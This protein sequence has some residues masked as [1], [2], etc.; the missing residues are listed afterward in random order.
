MNNRTLLLF[1]FGLLLF[2]GPAIAQKNNVNVNP[3]TGTANVV[4]PLYEFKRGQV[5][6]PINISYAASGIKPKDVEGTAGMGWQFNAGGQ[7]TRQVRGLPDDC[8]KDNTNLDRKGWMNNTN[9]TK[10]NSFSIANDNNPATC[11][12]GTNDVNYINTNFADLS[13]TEPDI[14]YVNAPGL[15]CQL[16]YDQVNSHFRLMDHQDVTIAYAANLPTAAS[17]P[18]AITSFT[19]TNDKGVR[20]IF[21]SPD[22]VVQTTKDGTPT[23]YKNKYDQYKNG[24]S[25]FNNW[26]LT[27]IL[28][29]NGSGVTFQYNFAAHFRDSTDPVSLYTP[30]ASTPTLQYNVSQRVTPQLLSVIRNVYNGQIADVLNFTWWWSSTASYFNT[31][32]GKY[33]EYGTGANLIKKIDGAGMQ[34]EFYY[35]APDDGDPV[36]GSQY[37]RYFLRSFS[38]YRCGSPINYSFRYAGENYTPGTTSYQSTL[39]DSSTKKIDYW[40]YYSTSNTSTT[41]IMPKVWI[42]ASTVAIP[43]YAI[44]QTGTTGG[45]YPYYTTN[46]NIRSADPTN[47]ISGSLTKIYYPE[48]GSTTLTYESNDYLDVPSG[49]VFPGNGIRTKQTVDDDGSGSGNLITTNYSYLDPATGISSGKPLSLPAFAF[50]IPYN[51][52][53]TGNAL[54][55]SCTVVSDNDLSYE[56]HTIMYAY[57]K[58]SKSGAGSTLYQYYIP[59]SYWNTSSTPSCSGCTVADWTPTVN[60]MQRITCST[61]TGP[62][63]KNTYGYPFTP[64]TNYDFER[65]LIK[66]TTYFNESGT[67]VGESNY[68]YQRS[69]QPSVITAL[70]IEDVPFSNG[71][72][73]VKTFAKYTVNYKVSELLVGESALVYDPSTLTLV[74][75]TTT[76]YSFESSNHR[77]MT[78]KAVTNSDNS[79]ITTQIKYV[80]DFTGL[81]TSSNRN[82]NALYNMQLL[83]QNI[84]VETYEQV[85]RAGSTKTTSASLVLFADFPAATGGAYNYRPFAQYSLTSADGLVAFSPSSVSLPSTYNKDP[86]YFLTANYSEYDKLGDLQSSDDGHHNV[87]ATVLDNYHNLPIISIHNAAAS[88]IGFAD[89][90]SNMLTPWVFAKTGTSSYTPPAGSHTGLATGLGTGQVISFQLKKN[91]LAT[92]YVLSAWINTTAAGNIAFSFSAASGTS[93][94]PPQILP[95]TG[96][97]WKYQEWKVSLGTI[98]GAFTINISTTVNTGV[99]DVIFYPENAEVS[100]YSYDPVT[101]FKASATNTNGISTYFTDDIW[102]RP[103]LT[104]DQDHN[105]VSQKSYITQTQLQNWNPYIQNNN[106][107]INANTPVTFEIQGWADNCLIPDAMVTWNFGDGTSTVTTQLV[108]PPAH[109]YATTGTFSVTA[110]VVSPVFG[111]KVTAPLSVTVHPALITINFHNYT[112]YAY[113]NINVNFYNRVTGV[114]TTFNPNPNNPVTIE[115]GNYDMTVQ[116]PTG[117][118]YNSSTGVGWS[119]ALLTGTGSVTSNIFLCRDWNMNNN[120]QFNN[121]NLSTTTGLTLDINTINC[122]LATQ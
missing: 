111:S 13:D 14:F 43:Q 51:G 22:L 11:T 71:T 3:L 113:Y 12:D 92:N 89:F 104:M 100:T 77:L 47:V 30:G 55:N 24:I 36:Y 58:Q 53:A 48:G 75:N 85:T 96:G 97:A 46:G 42:A 108:S 87:T 114:A 6:V 10:I 103:V 116:I 78:K 99:D 98:A 84:P 31:E 50:N 4:F 102:G 93:A 110:T 41:S 69:W 16:V 17:L 35:D 119:S 25:F 66:K 60:N 9:A 65:G 120:L 109:T 52:S 45:N 64:N 62:I 57:V 81:T 76:N 38:D 29:D 15:S 121:M 82:V 21:D 95:N 49:L 34:L 112:S 80:K 54:W 67:E 88:E 27:S 91:P 28:D 83:N 86:N 90:D 56:D 73:A 115:Q 26:H 20:Y 7:I 32:D 19:L 94:P 33:H 74:Q 107:V 118:L 2:A 39:P 61:V 59:A 101:H 23:Y 68:T 79:I 8:L 117:Q 40:G 70:K 106:G 44:Y 72:A 18:G 1:F 105:I 122:A 37:K 63:A 5:D